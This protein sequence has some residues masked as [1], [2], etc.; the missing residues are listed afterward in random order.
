MFTRDPSPLPLASCTFDQGG[1]QRHHCPTRHIFDESERREHLGEVG[2][3]GVTEFGLR[4][5]CGDDA[6]GV[7]QYWGELT[8]GAE[9]G[10]AE[11]G[12]VEDGGVDEDEEVG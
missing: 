9:G 5:P 8:G 10:L 1:G 12:D 6:L 4:A 3:T 2:S 7:G 11:P